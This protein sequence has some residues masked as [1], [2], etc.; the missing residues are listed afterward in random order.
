[1]C[2]WNRPCPQLRR[3]FQSVE[4]KDRSPKAI[5]YSMETLE[6]EHIPRT[7]RKKLGRVHTR[8]IYWEVRGRA[9]SR[10]GEIW[11]ETWRMGTSESGDLP[12]LATL[13]VCPVP[14]RPVGTGP[15]AVKILISVPGPH[16]GSSFPQ[17]RPITGDL[18]TF[19]NIT[20]GANLSQVNKGW[21]WRK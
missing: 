17:V 8:P 3:S 7:R 15:S 14:S 13:R 19:P 20:W 4:E 16:P 12:I 9:V 21:A 11:T 6:K 1:M 10:G 2:G 18:E 5:C